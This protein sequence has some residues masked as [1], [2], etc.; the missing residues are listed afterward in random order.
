MKSLKITIILLLSFVASFQLLS[1][2]E[3][4]V[5]GDSIRL[6][7]VVLSDGSQFTGEILSMDSAIISMKSGVILRIDI[8]RNAIKK[9]ERINNEVSAGTKSIK[10]KS[11]WISNPHATRYY[12]AP[13]AVP[14]SK[15]EGYYQ[16]AYLL[17]NSVNYGFSDHFSLGGGFEF[18]TT[19]SEEFDPIF[20]VTPKTGFKVSKNLYLGAGALI[21]SLGALADD[22]NEKLLALGYGIATY[23]NLDHNLS[24][25]VGN[26][27]MASKYESRPMI[28]FCGMTR[29]SNKFSLIT[30]NWFVPYKDKIFNWNE[31]TN[32][33]DI[34]FEPKY[35]SLF[36]YGIRYFGP[37][38]SFDFGLINNKDLAKVLLVGVPYIDIVLKF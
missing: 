25:A 7:K 37:K 29:I 14:L 30:E 9:I 38:F 5:D 22:N 13:S 3:M 31:V 18:L 11:D 19:F 32:Q 20:F 8:P 4:K 17:V 16:N 28:T 35:L 23:G 24:L 27:F 2:Q 33:S 34:T 36:S 1:A 10:S 6:Y 26:G 15:G 21:G 12:F